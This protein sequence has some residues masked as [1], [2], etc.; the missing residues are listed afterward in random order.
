GHDK[1]GSELYLNSGSTRIL[2][3]ER[4]F[5]DRR[6]L[7]QKTDCVFPLTE[8]LVRLRKIGQQPGIE[9]RLDRSRWSAQFPR[10][11]QIL[12]GAAIVA[13]LAAL[14]REVVERSDLL[15]PV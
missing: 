3:A 5:F 15:L 13:L 10:L 6:R 14:D 2:R 7:T 12:D 4:L 8:L 9:A 11:F 1:C